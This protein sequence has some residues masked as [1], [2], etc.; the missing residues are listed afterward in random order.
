M[1]NER[2]FKSSQDRV[3]FGVAGGLARYWNVDPVLVRLGFV[4][5]AFVSVGLGL[6]LYVALAL[7]MPRDRSLADSIPALSEEQKATRRRNLLAI[8]LIA[9]G[10]LFFLG[11]IS[12][13]FQWGYV[14]PLVLVGIGAA[15]I[16]GRRRAQ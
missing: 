10:G 2:L 12:T 4:V 14:W 1:M 13:W 8:G 9:V 11:G 16:I 3:V 6:L 15:I 5:L 7:I